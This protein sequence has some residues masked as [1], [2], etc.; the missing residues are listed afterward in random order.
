[1]ARSCDIEALI[2]RKLMTPYVST[3]FYR[4][5]ELIL[6]LHNYTTALDIWSVGCVMA[7]LYSGHPLFPGMNHQHMLQLIIQILG[8]PKNI[9]EF[10]TKYS[11]ACADALSRLP[12][13]DGS[14]LTKILGQIN[15]H[16]I[17]LIRK[18][19]CFDPVKIK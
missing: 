5:P 17:D 14:Y 18:M 2:P 16:A 15:P 19:L 11:A 7:E 8:T 6:S 10:L 12:Y 9:I 3:R 13:S 1:M 4:A